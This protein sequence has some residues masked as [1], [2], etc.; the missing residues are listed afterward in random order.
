MKKLCKIGKLRWFVTLT[1]SMSASYDFGDNPCP[2]CHLPII[3]HLLKGYDAISTWQE[4]ILFYLK[5]AESQWHNRP[6]A[7]RCG[8]NCI[9]KQE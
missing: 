8:Q 5:E 7:G 9:R 3:S 2:V 6:N 1:F 4:Q